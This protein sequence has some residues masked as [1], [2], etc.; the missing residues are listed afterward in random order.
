MKTIWF[1]IQKEFIQI[2][3][4]PLLVIIIF[5][6][7]FLQVL[8]LGGAGG[9]IVYS[10]VY[11][12]DQDLSPTSRLIT[13]KIDAS[14]F[15]E[16]KGTS[17]NIQD[18]INAMQ[19]E[20]IRMVLHF[21]PNFEKDLN[22]KK[23]VKVQLIFNAVEGLVAG[24]ASAYASQIISDANQEAVIKFVDIASVNSS[25]TID[26]TFT[27][28]YNNAMITQY[29]MVPSICVTMVVMITILLSGMN[30]VKEKEMGTMDQL[31]VTPLKK[32]Q[33]LIGKMFPVWLISMLLLVMGLFLGKFVFDVPILGKIWLVLGLSA[34]AILFLLGVGLLISMIA[35]TQQQAMFFTFFFII[36]FLI[37]GDFITPIENM[38]VW[39]QV[40]TWFNPQAYYS[41]MMH[42]VINKGSSFMDIYRDLILVT[43]FSIVL[44]AI[45]TKLYK[46]T[47]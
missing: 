17:F 4:N 36:V 41:R 15:F 20:N 39:A 44:L 22:R 37:M 40:L 45:T 7:P 11:V 35:N 29:V 18:G 33:F 32:N 38:P 2:F 6:Q 10:S 3:R 31:N 42:Q 28:W 12:V 24:L 30:I 27:H 14:S 43:I 16:V 8:L 26:V 5:S 25:P 34:V 47:A 46:K 1:I 13:S 23:T 9:D 19:K 21:P